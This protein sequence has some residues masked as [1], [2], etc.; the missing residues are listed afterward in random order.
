MQEKLTYKS[1]EL[2]VTLFSAQTDVITA[3]GTSSWDNL[4]FEGYGNN[5]WF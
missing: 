1:P 4:T 2:S 5:D 3:S